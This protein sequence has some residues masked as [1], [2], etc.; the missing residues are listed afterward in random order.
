MLI[1]FLGLLIFSCTAAGSCPRATASTEPTFVIGGT[2][3][4][5]LRV[6]GEDQPPFACVDLAICSWEWDLTTGDSGRI[7]VV[8]KT[9]AAGADCG[10][11]SFETSRGAAYQGAIRT[12][13]R[14]SATEARSLAFT[15]EFIKALS[16]ESCTA[17]HPP[18]VD[19]GGAFLLQ[20]VV[21]KD[22]L[23]L[24]LEAAWNPHAS[25]LAL[26]ISSTCDPSTTRPT[27]R[28]SVA[29]ASAGVEVAWQFRDENGAWVPNSATVT[30]GAPGYVTRWATAVSGALTSPIR[31]PHRDP[32]NSGT[33]SAAT[34]VAHL[35]SRWALSFG[36]EVDTNLDTSLREWMALVQIHNPQ[37]AANT[38]FRR[39]CAESTSPMKSC[40]N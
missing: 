1:R 21:I 9:A 26:R 28:L 27:D 25:S 20:A 36:S 32:L 34:G 14:A 6:F 33:G 18:T 39:E 38:L 15:S 7:R 8:A 35:I 24:C 17:K 23:S 22:G 2:N 4:P 31:L 10:D 5:M 40:S 30:S 16:P 11:E 37:T 12:N 13:C 29:T 19:S 3:S